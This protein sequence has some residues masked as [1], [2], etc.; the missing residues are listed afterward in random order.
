MKIR[1]F[2]GLLRD[3]ENKIHTFNYDKILKD[4]Q[5]NKITRADIIKLQDDVYRLEED[6]IILKD[7]S[8]DLNNDI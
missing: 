6:L 8:K 4:Y 5:M 1:Y 7:K 2:K 3:L